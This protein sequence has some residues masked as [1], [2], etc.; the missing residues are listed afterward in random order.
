MLSRALFIFGTGFCVGVGPGVLGQGTAP[1]Q[2]VAPVPPVDRQA[3]AFGPPTQ[4][5]YT[6]VMEASGTYVPGSSM[7]LGAT[8]LGDV[9]TWQSRFQYTGTFVTGG[10]VN[11][12]L[13]AELERFGFDREDGTGL[14]TMLGSFA[15]P[16]G[17]NWRMAPKWS[18]LAEV[19]PGLYTDFRDIGGTDFNAPILAGVSYA[20]NQD[21]LVLLQVSAD[22]RRDIP[23]VGGPGIRWR[24][25]PEWTLSL[26][27]PRPRVEYRPSAA[28]MFYVGG[29]LAGGAFRLAE[30][31]GTRRGDSRLDDVS[32]TYREIRAGAGA[33]WDIGGGWRAEAAGGWVIDRRFVVDE[34]RLTWNGDGAPYLRLQLSYRY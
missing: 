24:F 8:G 25:K 12:S 3:R 28:W 10:P 17:V 11:W 22:F 14:P 1:G 6:A 7:R 9:G 26:L 4:P 27:L 33:L 18:L 16:M 21:L 2:P 34:H 19:S 13:G 31:H 20:V 5:G 23:V 29:E 32:M 15:V 30:D